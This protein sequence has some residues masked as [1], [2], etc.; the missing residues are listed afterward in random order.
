MKT[1]GTSGSGSQCS[2]GAVVDGA[3]EDVPVIARDGEAVVDVAVAALLV[4]EQ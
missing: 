1:A 2:P 3:C 4:L